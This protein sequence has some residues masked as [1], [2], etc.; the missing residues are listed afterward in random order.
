MIQSKCCC[1][2]GFNIINNNC[3]SF[4]AKFSKQMSKREEEDNNKNVLNKIGSHM[5]GK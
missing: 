4:V 1:F 2:N 3:G 5:L